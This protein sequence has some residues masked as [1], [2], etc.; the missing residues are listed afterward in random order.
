MNFFIS[1]LYNSPFLFF[2]VIVSLTLSVCIHE[3][4]QAFAALKCG[5]STAADAGHLTLNPLK[6]M[7]VWSII[8]LLT[9]GFCWGAVPVNNACLTR[10]QRLIVALAGPGANLLLFACGIAMFVIAGNIASDILMPVSLIFAQLNIVLFFINIL[11]VPG[12]DGGT[13][14]S[15]LLP[16]HKLYSTEAG[17]GI[18][19]GAI[20][21]FFYSSSYIFD[22]ANLVTM[23]VANFFW[24]LF[25]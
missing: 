13:V 1:Q 7:G 20:L 17:K 10:K 8:M 25:A 11:P 14:L 4:C 16:M 2:T 21:L 22:L 3:F 23:Q 6:Q 18:M 5:D 12:F 24:G 19:L 15:E 9:M